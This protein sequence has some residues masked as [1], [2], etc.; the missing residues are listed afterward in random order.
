[1]HRRFTLI[2]LLVV[3]A[4]LGILTS[5]L[6]PSLSKAR[7]SAKASVCGSNLKQLGVGVEMYQMG[8]DGRT[9]PALINTVGGTTGW[10]DLVNEYFEASSTSISTMSPFNCPANIYQ[11]R[12]TGMGIGRDEVSYGGNG[13]AGV[14][15]NVIPII[16]NPTRALG[17]IAD[18][19]KSPT[20]LYL[21]AD[22]VYYSIE[23]HNGGLHTICGADNCN[24]VNADHGGT[25]KYE[26][27]GKLNM[28]FTDKHVERLKNVTVKTNTSVNWYAN[29]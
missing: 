17:V 10:H 19:V 22:A 26:H 21:L 27:L 9:P 15:L 13:W 1:M 28:L 3:V 25:L 18:G 6:L 16:N 4:I 24:S 23:N 8:S 11:T 5:I 2:E 20:E 14:R 7:A 29:P 12:W